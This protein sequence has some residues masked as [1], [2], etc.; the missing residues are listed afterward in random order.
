MFLG[1]V[2]DNIG[3][4]EAASGAAGIV[5]CIM[6]MQNKTIAKQA[7]FTRLNPR[8]K[9]SDKITIPIENTPWNA[10]RRV[11]L[12]NNYGASGSIAALALR[13][14]E[15]DYHPAGETAV[16]QGSV[17]TVYPILLA[18][19]SQ[20]SLKGY[21]NALGKFAAAHGP[22]IAD[23]AY[24]VAWQQNPAFEYR[25]AVTA[26]DA[27]SLASALGQ[28]LVESE[29]AAK[30]STKQP[31]VLCFGGQTGDV[32]TLSKDLYEASALLRHY[33]A[34][35][36]AACR[37]IGLPSIFPGIFDNTPVEDLVS[38]H[39]RLFSLQFSSAKCWLDSGVKIDSLIGHSF[40]Q[41]TALCVADSMSVKDGLRLISGRARL[42]RDEWSQERGVMLSVEGDRPEIESLV[43]RVNLQQGCRVDFA[44]YNGPRAFVLAGDTSSIDTLEEACQAA[45]SSSRIKTT[46]L[47]NSRAYHSYLAEPM[48]SGL[49]DVV[50]S[51]RLQPP[52]IH[53]EACFPNGT[54]WN[55]NA[56][57][58]VQHTRQPVY[59][60]DAVQR[61]A[62]R[63]PSAIWLEAGSASPVI[64]MIR[65]IVTSHPGSGNVLIPV[66]IGTRDAT[67]NLANA[68]C[69]LW[70]AGS[71]TRSWLFHRRQQHDY[72]KLILPPYQFEKTKHWIEYKHKTEAQADALSTRAESRERELVSLIQNQHNQAVFLVETSHPFFDLSAR[73]HAVAGQSLCP[74][75]MYVELAARCATALLPTGSAR[76]LPQIEDLIMSAPLGLSAGITVFVNLTA[77]SPDGPWTFAVVSRPQTG[78]GETEHAKGRIS[79]ARPDDVVA[80]GR[81]KLL[82]RL[83]RPSRAAQIR[84]SPMATGLSGPMVYKVFRDV[85]E[86]APYYHGVKHLTGLD[87]EAV[88]IVTVPTKHVL[89]LEAGVCDP[90]SLDNFLQVAGIH[91]NCLSDRRES[92]VF[93]CTAVE[94]V[95][96]SAGYLDNRAE[97]RSWTVYTRYDAISRNSI[98]NDIFVFDSD[99]QELVLSVMGATFKSVPFK[100]VARSLSR[101]NT[102]SSPTSAA[103]SPK[104]SLSLSEQDHE[105]LGYRS[106]TPRTP[107]DEEMDFSLKSSS[108]ETLRPHVDFISLPKANVKQPPPKANQMVQT[109]RQILSEII[110]I[111]L[112]EVPVNA[113]F[114]DLGI[115]SLLVTEVLTEIQKHLRITMT[116]AEF[117]E[118]PDIPTLC[119]HLEPEAVPAVPVTNGSTKA[120]R[121]VASSVAVVTESNSLRQDPVKF[122]R[123][124]NECFA[125]VKQT[126]DSYAKA[127]G[128]ANFR[129]DVFPLQS[130]LVV[131]YVVEA[132]AS[133]GCDISTVKAG[134]DIPALSYIPKHVKLVRQ[135]YKVLEEAGLVVRANDAYQ[136]TETKVSS[137]PSSTIL[138]AMLAQFPQHSAET[139][140]LHSTAQQLAECLSG[141]ADPI[142]ILFGDASARA[143]LEDMYTN[144]PMFKA[145]TL[146][147][148]D[149][150]SS[151]LGRF[152]DPKRPVHILELGAGT[153]GT[154]KKLL[155]V[156]TASPN[157]Q[158]FTYTFTDLSS[159]LV[160]AAKRKF[161]K[162]PFM[163]YSVL[164]IEADPES[165]GLLGQFDIVISTNCIHATRDLVASTSHI[166]QMLRPDGILCLVEATRNLFWFDL[167][168][169]LLE[170]WW[171]ATDGRDH[172]LAD[173]HRWERDLKAAG[174][175]WVDWSDSPSEESDV[176]R[177]ITASPSEIVPALVLNGHREPS[178][179]VTK[180]T[181]VYKEVNGLGIS[182]DIYYPAE[183]VQ[184][185][186]SFPVGEVH[187]PRHIALHATDRLQL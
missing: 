96:L 104:S 94:E 81:L 167:V 150:L 99:T 11:A 182:A 117:Q 72:T 165:S 20:N 184:S 152:G 115:D 95:F 160:V 106:L 130:Q 49:A 159:S 63:V 62:E 119:R 108:M 144:A 76:R 109:V 79:L 52:R 48:L 75:S 69:H 65:R 169:G 111:P 153:G 39:C 155:E 187:F 8:I 176:L 145:G 138:A 161:A 5:K 126:Y 58:L 113:N 103:T 183:I 87:N 68:T 41:L 121:S 166:R 101:L 132:F 98:A 110:E 88:G 70:K 142:G 84:A 147:L 13:E 90:I 175:R 172:P 100:A 85:V 44:C 136:R 78:F 59:F 71:R 25:A 14:P 9:A 34:Q 7:S 43:R 151:V 37:D 149:Y 124:S 112:A 128:F 107:I 102:I 36:D 40:G 86:Y 22:S 46:R 181:L 33:L 24:S 156:L 123:V 57:S 15:Q 64:A 91:V 55:L 23:L 12:I 66:D 139:K 47:K 177:V 10:S 28:A 54:S 157:G 168:F 137:V 92:E 6:M 171:L 30:Q 50:R 67:K 185:S 89:G 143:L 179:I 74:A 174:F 18:A 29:S 131:Q 80:A 45:K 17:P 154:T 32:V 164:D 122:A 82:K 77:E 158:N 97:N 127:T 148:A 35:C 53:V 140:L 105:D 1:A 170:G 2:K 38:L 26:F 93:M 42:M 116:P 56:E 163:R 4:A 16:R 21:I 135:M 114:E 125:T 129:A 162:Y 141:T 118:C 61:I 173:E 73:G 19:K 31:V 83:A 51:I 27:A 60:S 120:L 3:H 134:S 178:P 180:E 133:L 146:L 186:Q